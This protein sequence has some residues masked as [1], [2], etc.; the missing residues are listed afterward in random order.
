MEPHK[1]GNSPGPGPEVVKRQRVANEQVARRIRNWTV[2][3]EMKGVLEPV[4]AGAKGTILD[5][6]NPEEKRAK[7]KTVVVAG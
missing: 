2:Q 1:P 3:N 6:A 5:S 4:S 7:E